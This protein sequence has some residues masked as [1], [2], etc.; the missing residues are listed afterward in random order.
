MVP[1]EWKYV[2]GE[3]CVVRTFIVKE[4]DQTDILD[5][6]QIESDMQRDPELKI[7]QVMW[8]KVSSDDPEAIFVRASHNLLQSWY[9]YSLLKKKRGNQAHINYPK[10]AINFP[11]LYSEWLPI[12]VEKKKDLMAMSEYLK[13]CYRGFYESLPSK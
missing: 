12:S 7:T 6:S 9:R 8:L 2:I 13:P 1:S 5:L 3:A 10:P 4:M 11:P